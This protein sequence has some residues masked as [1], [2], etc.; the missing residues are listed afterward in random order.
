MRRWIV[1]GLCLSMLALA[2]GL[3]PAALAR[4]QQVAGPSIAE[5]VGNWATYVH[6]AGHSGYNGAEQAIN[7]TSAPGLKRV[8]RHWT[9]GVTATQPIVIGNTVYWGS[10]DGFEHATNATTGAFVWAQWLGTTAAQCGTIVG[11]FGPL[12]SSAKL[13]VNAT[14]TVTTIGSKAMLFVGGGARQVFALNPA[15][16]AIIWQKTVSS[17]PNAFLWSS[18]VVYN[19]NV[20]IAIASIGDC[21][22]VAGQIVELSGATGAILHTFTTVPRGCI[23]AGVWGTPT[24]D[25]AAGTLYFT[26]GNPGSCGTSEP[27]AE[28]IVELHASDLSVVHS[29]QVP[30]SQRT[31]DGDFGA[32][33]TLFTATING[34]LHALV[35]AANKNGIF[36]VWDRADIS[37]GTVWEKKVAVAGA[38]PECGQ[39]SIAP[40]AWDGR[41]LFVAGGNTTINGQSCKG[42]VRALNPATGAFIW[43]HCMLSGPVLGA[44]T[45]VPGVVAATEANWLIL[46]ATANGATLFRYVVADG[47]PF[48]GG[49]SVS[50][51]QLYVGNADGNL[52]AFKP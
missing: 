1:G 24:I 51:G 30:A 31:G 41:R 25:T 4:E 35:G 37:A 12:A 43:E 32:T 48:F 29:W 40:V 50:Q 44:V 33:P 6:D 5:A 17:N 7:P 10:W 52:F 19:G 15:N 23:G 14:A 34:T 47:K 45:A 22:L 27:Y 2:V 26:T 8:W 9:S 18:P 13:G 3:S 28:S 46:M 38:C 39:G 20:Y 42:S 21:P 36:Y 49:A 11:P 16:G